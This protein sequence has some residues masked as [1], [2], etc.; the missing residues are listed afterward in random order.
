M[1]TAVAYKQHK[2][3][4]NTSILVED[5]LPSETDFLEAL[6]LRF[7]SGDNFLEFKQS[8]LN[9]ESEV[10]KQARRLNVQTEDSPLFRI[11]DDLAKRLGIAQNYLVRTEVVASEARDVPQKEFDIKGVSKF[12]NCS[13]ETVR[14][15]IK[16]MR[17]QAR[18]VGGATLISLEDAEAFK[19]SLR[20]SKR[21]LA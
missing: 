14:K 13:Y 16:S 17:L 2:T 3:L 9:R 18:R 15:A 10:I 11:C 12:V 8:Y 6:L 7:F 4:E 19:S 20:R 1:I 21:R 5:F